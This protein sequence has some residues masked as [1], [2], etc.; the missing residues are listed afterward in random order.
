MSTLR[1]TKKIKKMTI[2]LRKRDIYERVNLYDIKFIKASSNYSIFQTTKTQY[3]I[4]KTLGEI[5][6]QLSR[7]DEQKNFIRVNRSAIINKSH[8]DAVYGRTL[9][10]SDNDFTVSGPHMEVLVMFPVI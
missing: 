9:Y 5:E 7:L 8:V 4:S 3:V 1:S 6:R 2:F 10:I